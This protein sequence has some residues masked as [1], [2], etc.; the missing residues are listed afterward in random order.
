MFLLATNKKSITLFSLD[1]V[2]LYNIFS[3]VKKFKL[4]DKFQNWKTDSYINGSNIFQQT[5]FII[6]KNTRFYNHGFEEV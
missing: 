3:K 2:L 1:N 6:L 5:F 4:S